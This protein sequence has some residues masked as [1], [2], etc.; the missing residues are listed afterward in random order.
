MKRKFIST[1]F[2]L[3]LGATIIPAAQ[4]Q[5]DK[6]SEVNSTVTP[7]TALQTPVLNTT[8]FELVNLANNGYLRDQGIP[9][10]GL[11][12]WEVNK[13]QLTATDL[14]KA[15]IQTNKV[16]STAL[17]DSGYINAVQL[18]LDDLNRPEGN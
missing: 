6:P 18:M 2:V 14:V 10:N 1:F 12:A 5:T 15:A 7:T 4:A 13:G 11:L 3:A 8:P 16:P 17:N 9:A